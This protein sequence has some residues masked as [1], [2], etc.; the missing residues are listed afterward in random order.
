[1]LRLKKGQ[2]PLVPFEQDIIPKQH[3]FLSNLAP[4]VKLQNP[5]KLLSPCYTYSEAQ[6]RWSLVHMSTS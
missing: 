4:G 2:E 3:T 6:L 5:G 1:M